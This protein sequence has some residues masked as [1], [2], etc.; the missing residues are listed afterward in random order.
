M[1]CGARR[2]HWKSRRAAQTRRALVEAMNPY[3]TSVSGSSSET[4]GLWSLI[5][6]FAASPSA[7]WWCSPRP[8][9]VRLTLGGLVVQPSPG[10]PLMLTEQRWC[11]RALSISAPA[12]VRRPPPCHRCVRPPARNRPCTTD[13][14]VPATRPPAHKLLSRPPSERRPPVRP[15]NLAHG[16]PA[17]P[18]PGFPRPRPVTA[19]CRTRRRSPSP[20]PCAPGC[21]PPPDVQ[22][23][24]PNRANGPPCWW[25]TF[26]R[27]IA[28]CL[29][30]TDHVLHRISPAS[31]AA[32]ASPL[33]HDRQRPAPFRSPWNEA[34]SPDWKECTG[35]RRIEYVD[36]K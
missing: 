14:A 17:P 22:R 26:R 2:R 19:G 3:N 8:A 32:P 23:H 15:H 9:P 31:P 28:P 18:Y 20:S 33:L 11:S 4:E 34:C 6:F 7:A 27:G 35:A 16:L 21:P 1:S 36:L 30:W 25:A 29:P 12:P 10:K 13:P 5:V 24:P